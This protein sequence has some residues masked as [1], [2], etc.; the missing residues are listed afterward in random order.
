MLKR[1]RISL[2]LGLC[3]AL[4]GVSQ[5]DFVPAGTLNVLDKR[6]PDRVYGSLPETVT[7]GNRDTNQYADAVTKFDLSSYAGQTVEGD[8]HILFYAVRSGTDAEL[9][10]G[11]QILELNKGFIAS[12]V[13]W[14]SRSSGV[15]WTTTT[16]KYS[17]GGLGDTLGQI[18]TFAV[19]WATDYV[20]VSVT[21]S[22]ETI[23]RWIDAPSENFGL[24]F[25][26]VN[27]NPPTTDKFK[28]INLTGP[29]NSTYGG[30]ILEFSSVPEPATMGLLLI[31]TAAIVLKRRGT[32]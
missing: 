2:I 3:I 14:N 29:G 21:V 13:S 11:F 17:A 26:P 16:N 25:A 31:G 8:G 18:G 30:P 6:D 22:Q 23:Q 9:P 15:A 7:I 32:K 20:Q 24:I 28:R 1:S 27:L 12:E 10:G 19:T 4:A 5:A